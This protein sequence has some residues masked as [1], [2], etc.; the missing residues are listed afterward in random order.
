[1]TSVHIQ[2]LEITANIFWKFAYTIYDKAYLLNLYFYHF[3]TTLFKLFIPLKILE[4]KT[5]Y[6]HQRIIRGC[7]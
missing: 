2:K 7:L 5:T 4:A 3:Q 1:M 6:I